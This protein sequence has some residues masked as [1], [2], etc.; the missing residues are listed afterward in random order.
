MNE[1]L[2]RATFRQMI[3]RIMQ[4]NSVKAGYWPHVGSCLWHCP[5]NEAAMQESIDQLLA[6]A[7]TRHWFH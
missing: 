2:D 1:Q 3:Q 5:P 4:R 7:H 6:S